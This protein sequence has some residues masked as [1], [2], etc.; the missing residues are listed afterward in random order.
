MRFKEKVTKREFAR[1]IFFGGGTVVCLL[2]IFLF[3][4]I[5]KS[6]GRSL[7]PLAYLWPGQGEDAGIPVVVFK[8]E[9]ERQA[10]RSDYQSSQPNLTA[11]MD[12]IRESTE[13]RQAKGRGQH[14]PNRTPDPAG[15]QNF[16]SSSV[17]GVNVFSD[18]SRQK[19][20]RGIRDSKFRASDETK[21]AFSSEVLPEQREGASSAIVRPASVPVIQE[22]PA[23]LITVDQNIPSAPRS[24]S[25]TLKIA[26]SATSGFREAL[27]TPGS[28]QASSG[29][30]SLSR[31]A[32]GETFAPEKDFAS[33]ASFEER[34]TKAASPERGTPKEPAWVVQMRKDSPV[35]KTGPEDSFWSLSQEH[36]GAGDYFRALAIFNGCRKQVDHLP[37][38]VQVPSL[39]QIRE[40]ASSGWID[41]QGAL[42]PDAAEIRS[43]IHLTGKDETLFRIARERLGAGA[44]FVD[45][46]NANRKRLPENCD[47]QTKLK[48]GIRLI[49]PR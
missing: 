44:R 5:Q 7:S 47:A 22:K 21:G 9:K 33:R 14:L 38:T 20:A 37:P 12:R 35:V 43:G 29:R 1:E 32:K 10:A 42:D 23:R 28:R 48:P 27:Q 13:K 17:A 16:G 26:N 46:Y 11:M 6:T 25:P 36:Y 8:S 41:A 34:E 19:L 18:A 40:L 30:N 45:I 4:A 49:L 24:G 31:T 15:R 3:V 39:K 2:A